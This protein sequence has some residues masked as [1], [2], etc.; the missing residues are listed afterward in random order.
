MPQAKGNKKICSSC[1]KNKKVDQ[2][3]KHKNTADN[4]QNVCKSCKAQMTRNWKYSMKNGEIARMIVE[5]NSSCAIC[6]KKT[7]DIVLDHDHKTGKVRQLLCRKCNALLGMCD[8]NI[9]ILNTA[10][11]YINKWTE[12]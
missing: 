7:D 12:E 5:Q 1:K 6:L 2:F 10:I 11:A 9:L 4:L 8:D 3:N